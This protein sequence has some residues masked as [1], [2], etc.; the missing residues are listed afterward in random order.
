MY[1]TK[2][3]QQRLMSDRVVKSYFSRNKYD[4]VPVKIL[5]QAS[6]E[7]VVQRLLEPLPSPE[8]GSDQSSSPTRTSNLE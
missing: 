8:E 4:C 2:I 1:R 7:T 5:R 3:F 6:K